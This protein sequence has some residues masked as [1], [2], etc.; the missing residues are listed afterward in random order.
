MLKQVGGISV[1]T[2][3]PSPHFFAAALNEP[4]ILCTSLLLII[5]FVLQC[6]TGCGGGGGQAPTNVP[7]PLPAPKVTSISPATG[8]SAGGTPVTIVGTGF[9]SGAT[10]SL[11][12]SICGSATVA[13]ANQ[14]TCTSGAHPSELVNVAVANP[15][16][17]IGT[18][19]LGFEY[20][21]SLFSSVLFVDGPNGLNKNSSLEAGE[22]ALAVFNGK[23]YATW[24]EAALQNTGPGQVRVAVY[25]GDDSAPAWSFVDGNGA[26]GINWD[27]THHAQFASLI[28]SDGKLY[29]TWEEFGGTG[30]DV[31]VAVYNG[32]DTSPA[33]AFVDGNSADGLD[34]NPTQGAADPSSL[35]VFN[36]SLYVTW[37]EFVPLWN[38]SAAVNRVAVYNG[39]DSS[40]QW[41]FIDGNNPTG[42][43]ATGG[44]PKLTPF[45]SKLYISGSGVSVNVYRNDLSPIAWQLVNGN[46]AFQVLQ[47]NTADSAANQVATD[48]NSKLYLMWSEQPPVSESILPASHI[49]AVVYNGNDSAPAWRFVDGNN[50]NGIDVGLTPFMAVAGGHLYSAWFE[51]PRI[52]VATYN[53]SDAAPGWTFVDQGGI[54]KDPAGRA[55]SEW[56]AV[57]NSKLYVAWEEFVQTS[58]TTG[59]SLVH[60]ALMQ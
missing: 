14:I 58:T 46:P 4:R 54:T 52:R 10:V 57:L 40:P 37:T 24:T 29:A 17:A 30:N 19:S 21:D 2:N 6:A 1:R 41:S 31:R 55:N 26:T 20:R 22:P 48:Y 32:D 42:G 28:A 7:P 35:A 56:M 36:G 59:T 18:L 38:L 15:G 51:D 12:D 50:A 49:R 34:E 25:N 47:W 3:S 60:V 8:L 43:L 33:W 39:N 5:L 53:G 23:L 11:G 45:N 44:S 9:T 13:S 16:G 27:T